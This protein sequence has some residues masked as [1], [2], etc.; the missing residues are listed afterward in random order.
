MAI[1]LQARTLTWGEGQVSKSAIT[2]NSSGAH[3]VVFWVFTT[4]AQGGAYR[5]VRAM[6]DRATRP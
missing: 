2:L 3:G 6:S 5:F 4:H 1:P